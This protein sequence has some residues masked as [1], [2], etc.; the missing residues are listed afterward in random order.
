MIFFSSTTLGSTSF[1][2]LLTLLC[3]IHYSDAKSSYTSN[4]NGIYHNN[5]YNYCETDLCPIGKKHIG[6]SNKGNKF[7]SKCTSDVQVVKIDDYTR[8]LILHLHNEYRNTIAEG[9]TVS[10][11]HI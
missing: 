1:L 6:C 2:V 4:N 10:S 11:S 3:F 7:G 9:R 5:N 8:R